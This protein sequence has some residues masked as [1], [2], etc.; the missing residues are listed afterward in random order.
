[1]TRYKSVC[2]YDPHASEQSVLKGVFLRQ[3]TQDFQ[4]RLTAVRSDIPIS[5]ANSLTDL[6]NWRETNDIDA[7]EILAPNIG[8]LSEPL[9]NLI[10]S[11]SQTRVSVGLLQRSWDTM[12]YPLCDKGFFTLWERFKRRWEQREELR[13]VVPIMSAPF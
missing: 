8:P 1:M 7:V 4:A 10:A 2:I 12:L 13:G 6:A 5:V 3:A 9:I 11:L